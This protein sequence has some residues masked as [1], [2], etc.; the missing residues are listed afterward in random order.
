MNPDGDVVIA[1]MKNRKKS[2]VSKA[3]VGTATVGRLSKPRAKRRRS[4]P[5]VSQIVIDDNLAN[6]KSI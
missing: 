5:S 6:A 4:K 2:V 1:V 3:V